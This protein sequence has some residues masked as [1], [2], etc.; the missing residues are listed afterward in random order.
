M[1][2]VPPF[3]GM[4]PY[5]E[6]PYRWPEIHTWLIVEIARSLNPQLL[7]RYRAAVETR[8]YIDASLVGIPDASIYTQSRQPQ[9]RPT[10]VAVSTRPER[11]TLPTT[12]E[13]TER[14]LEIR[15]VSTKRVVTI[16]EV[17]SPANKRSGE[18]RKK[19]LEK[20][21]RVLNSETHLIEIDLLRKGEPMPAA[22]GQQADYQ[23]I[24]SRASERPSAE[25]YAF[26]LKEKI[27]QFLLPLAA[28][29]TEPSIDIGA[30]L[31]QVCQDTAVEVDIDYTSQPQ[32]P[33]PVEDFEWVQSLKADD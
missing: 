31:Q 28:E 30:L 23:I 26:N 20:R 5:L 18:G 12:C 13:V 9:A 1:T 24:V 19:Y 27:P 11:I 8:V 4:N 25:R 16:I 15:E 7:P 22:G 14:Y 33:L 6:S 21:Q 3:P 29:D 2:S 17:L 10:A 32:P